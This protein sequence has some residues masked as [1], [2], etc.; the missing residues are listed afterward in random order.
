MFSKEVIRKTISHKRKIL[1]DE[2]VNELS[3]KINYNLLQF[4][5]YQNVTNI[6]FYTSKDNEVNLST[7][8][9]QAIKEGKN[10]ILPRVNPVTDNL[11][12]HIISD[13]DNDFELGY[14]GIYEP[15]SHLTK[16]DKQNLDLILVPGIAFDTKGNR[17]G[18][19]KGHFDK[20]L[21]NIKVP[22]IAVAYNFQLV[23]E[24]SAE[25]HDIK[26]DYI[27]T[28]DKVIKCQ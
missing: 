16:F 15:K 27:I 17:I 8:I 23:K 1:T 6:M 21:Q 25:D 26:M 10:V 3:E 13:L 19:G 28:E 14:A 2:K 22:K 9:I 5:E 12:L 24:I 18:Y 7:T 20:F 4:K 11:Q